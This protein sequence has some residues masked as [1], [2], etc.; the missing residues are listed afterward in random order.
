MSG[1]LLNIGLQP[2]N[3]S[4][5]SESFHPWTVDSFVTLVLVN[6]AGFVACV[7]GAVQAAGA[8]NVRTQLTWCNLGLFGL[9]L[10]GA[11]N[12]VWLYRGRRT[13]GLA[14]ST[15]LVPLTAPSRGSGVAGVLLVDLDH[16]EYHRP[17]C[18]LVSF[19]MT[20]P[21]DP[22]EHISASDPCSVCAP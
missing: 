19:R 5:S 10:S 9:A 18:P 15:L 21:A 11:C 2:R 7:A 13:V 3:L 8:D 6:L 20:R 16:G 17:T 14:T 12:G 1:S 22:R 4:R